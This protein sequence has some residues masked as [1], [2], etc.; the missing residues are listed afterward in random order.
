VTI[1]ALP[2]E[3]L[4]GCPVCNHTEASFVGHYPEAYLEEG[5]SLYQCAACS[6]VY[7]NPRLSLLG[8]HMLEDQSLV[9]QYDEV[10]QAQAVQDR[11]GIIDWIEAMTELTPGR[12]LDVGCN[13]GYLLAA[14]ARRGWQTTG[15]E[16]SQVAAAEARKRFGL[17]IYSSLS[18]LPK[19]QPFDLITCWHVVEHLHEPVQMLSQLAELLSPTGVLAIQVPAY[20]FAAEYVRQGNS[21]HIFCASHPVHYTAETLSMVLV[22]A[23]FETFY[24]DESAEHLLLTIYAAKPSRQLYREHLS[25][26]NQKL[27]WFERDHAKLAQQLQ[28]MNEYVQRLEATLEAKNQHIAQLEQNLKTIKNGRMMRLLNKLK[29]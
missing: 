27:I 21:S 29:G 28:A 22:K 10:T 24:C 23:G 12:M 7:L 5:L 6:L 26:I 9:Y 18:D 8:T 4:T 13:R 19:N 15:V 3:R 2:T 20:R 25:E 1:Q 17:T 16:L 11:E 14:A